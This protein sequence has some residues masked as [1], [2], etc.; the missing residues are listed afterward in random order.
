MKKDDQ[1]LR[2]WLQSTLFKKNN[3]GYFGRKR[4]KT[5]LVTDRNKALILHNN[6]FCLIWK[7]E[8]YFSI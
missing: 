6:H 7:S 3:F 1:A 8:W 4:N 2:L 5:R